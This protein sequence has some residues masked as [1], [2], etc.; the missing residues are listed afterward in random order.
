MN[1]N[2]WASA[3]TQHML[4]MI[5]AYFGYTDPRRPRYR[6]TRI[7]G[8]GTGMVYFSTASCTAGLSVA[9]FFECLKTYVGTNQQS[10]ANDLGIEC[11]G[12]IVPPPDTFQFRAVL[13]ANTSSNTWYR[14]E[15][16]EN[17]DAEWGRIHQ[18]IS[19]PITLDTACKEVGLFSLDNNRPVLLSGTTG[20]KN[21]SIPSKIFNMNCPQRAQSLRDCPFDPS[22]YINSDYS[23]HPK[24]KKKSKKCLF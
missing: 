19:T 15:M 1:N 12:P 22:S 21:Y 3:T 14:I 20:Y 17:E 13:V 23:A 11:E 18:S 6:F 10:H 16:R 9:A 4:V 24:K 2:G 8:P 5:C 7:Y